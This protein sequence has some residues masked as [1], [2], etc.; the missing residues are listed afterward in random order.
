MLINTGYELLI[1]IE[2]FAQLIFAGLIMIPI[3]IP[4]TY[5]L[6]NNKLTAINLLKLN[7]ITLAIGVC[8]NLTL[9]LIISS[10]LN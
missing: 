7:F 6:F 9:Q 1:D 2:D 3:N 8:L 4:S 10:Y 5:K